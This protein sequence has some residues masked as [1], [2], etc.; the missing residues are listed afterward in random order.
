MQRKVLPAS[1]CL[2]LATLSAPAQ[3]AV[4]ES[5]LYPPPPHFV[6]LPKDATLAHRQGPDS[7]LRRMEATYGAV[8]SLA[9]RLKVATT[10]PVDPITVAVFDDPS[11]FE[12][13][14]KGVGIAAAK[15]LFGFYDPDA[16]SVVLLDFTRVGAIPE[17]RSEI[18][19]LVNPIR[20]LGSTTDVGESARRAAILKRGEEA[21][22]KI[23][24]LEEQIYRTTVQH[25]VAHAALSVFGVLPRTST[26]PAWLNEGLASL[27]EAPI[28]PLAL[29]SL[30]TNE[31]RLNDYQIAAKAG[32][33]LPWRR[34]LTD[35]GVF[36]PG[37]PAAATAYAQAW[38]LTHW[39]VREKAKSMGDYIRALRRGGLRAREHSDLFERTFDIPDDRLAATLKRYADALTS[40]TK[41]K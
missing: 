35:D 12:S 15:D 31:F 5:S 23:D 40:T 30:A 24:Q 36:K 29:D 3:T 13:Y 21:F 18:S 16:R 22:A 38:L 9:N 2:L 37:Q 28:D 11:G 27:F 10:R 41:P 7:L 25:E 26:Q 8:Y 32:Q 17:K 33:L 19:R 34:L 4:K 20:A 1:T 39:A 6:I 14:A